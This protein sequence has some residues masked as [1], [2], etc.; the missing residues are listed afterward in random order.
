ML[1][2][3]YG[4]KSGSTLYRI[5][6]NNIY[7]D[8]T[9]TSRN[10]DFIFN[11]GYN[12]IP[13]TIKTNI[14]ITKMFKLVGNRNL[15]KHIK[16]NY[17]DLLQAIV[18]CDKEIF[19]KLLEPKLKVVLY[20]D[21]ARLGEDGYSFKIVN[22]SQPMYLKYIGYYELEGVEL[23]RDKNGSIED[24]QFNYK[25]KNRIVVSKGKGDNPYEAKTYPEIQKERSVFEKSECRDRAYNGLCDELSNQYNFEYAKKK[26]GKNAGAKE[27]EY[28][29]SI[30]ENLNKDDKGDPYIKNL[31]EEFRDYF[32]LRDKYIQDHVS[33]TDLY[34]YFK[35]KYPGQYKKLFDVKKG[36]VVSMIRGF[37]NR[38]RD[39][40]GNKRP[41]T[42]K[43]LCVIDVEIVSKMRLD[44][45]NTTTNILESY[46]YTRLMKNYRLLDKRNNEYLN[47]D[48]SM[49]NF[50]LPESKWDIMNKEFTQS[51]I[52]RFE[53][54]K[55]SFF[56]NL[57]KNPYKK[58]IITD[59]DLVLNG[60]KHF[61]YDTGNT[62]K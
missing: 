53:F 21:L 48:T 39:M 38:F 37:R 12:T 10:L 61:T 23:D 11:I 13:D 42:S 36:L 58:M 35:S 40:F 19:D 15:S 28:I 4:L 8:N 45:T 57:I 20:R 50:K 16:K 22:P 41:L 52:L 6:K 26:V 17:N 60:N 54:E 14:G 59:I 43:K 46:D 30:I 25:G 3:K 5:K 18:N 55:R 34:L 9:T 31:K 32:E 24:F 1:L 33:N 44:I 62:F 47:Y 56:S 51:H 7:F 29:A 2:N 49:Y 27:I